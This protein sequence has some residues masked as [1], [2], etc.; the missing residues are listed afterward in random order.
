MLREG[1]YKYIGYMVEGE[2]EELYDL[3]VD[4]DELTNIASEPAMQ[5]QLLALRAATVAELK[6]TDAGIAAD[7]PKVAGQ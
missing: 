2:I 3:Q 7:L 4:P 1:K 6:R 5:K